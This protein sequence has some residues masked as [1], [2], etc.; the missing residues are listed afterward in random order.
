ML[1]FSLASTC[2][3]HTSP[4]ATERKGYYPQRAIADAK[5]T[6][7]QPSSAPVRHVNQPGCRR[8]L[9]TGAS[10][11]LGRELARQLAASGTSLSLWGR[12]VD[13]L[14]AAA[15]ECRALGSEVSIRSLD[16]AD[17]D[18]AL[19]ALVA[20]DAD[21]PFDLVLLVAGQ[22]DTLG[23]GEVV[24]DPC[25]VARLAQ[26]NFVAPAALA[27]AIAARMAARGGGRIALVGT[28]AAFHS[29]PFAAAY[30][31]SKAGLARFADALRLAVRSHGVS[32]TL[33]APGF[34][35]VAEGGTPGRRR[36]FEVRAGV[37]AE[38]IIRATLRGQ[39]RLVTPQ[40]FML[41]RWL[42][43]LLPRPLRDRLLLGLRLP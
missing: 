16:L 40:P 27:A 10:G 11:K 25:Q 3:S 23:P 14:D 37:V 7:E 29:L 28:A 5:M 42:D 2:K 33:A 34:F 8:V 6:P 31:G 36:P 39:P 24:E 21:D 17:L 20:E 43:R 4:C 35:T 32:V 1:N 15:A 38:R 26:V 13:A 41:L 22:G 30:S 9:L 12:S 18:A 19:A